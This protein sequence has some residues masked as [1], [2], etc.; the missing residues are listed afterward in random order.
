MVSVGL[1]WPGQSGIETCRPKHPG[2]AECCAQTLLSRSG[3]EE[4]RN[5]GLE[6]FYLK[7]VFNVESQ[8]N[9]FLAAASFPVNVEE[10][11]DPKVRRKRNIKRNSVAARQDGLPVNASS[12]KTDPFPDEF[13]DLRVRFTRKAVRRHPRGIV[14][15]LSPVRQAPLHRG[16]TCAFGYG[17]GWQ[18]R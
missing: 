8:K 7:P 12:C 1:H 16:G 6:V 10:G 5:I 3:Q 11:G 14:R 9:R 2:E 4:K 17:S 18:N 15:L 13:A